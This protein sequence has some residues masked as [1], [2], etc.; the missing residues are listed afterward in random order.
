MKK[1]L[2]IIIILMLGMTN[3]TLISSAAATNSSKVIIKNTTIKCDLN[4]AS[5]LLNLKKINVKTIKYENQLY[6]PMSDGCYYFKARYKIL[7][8]EKVVH[9]LPNGKSTIKKP[10]NKKLTAVKARDISATINKYTFL[11]EGVNE[12]LDSILYENTIYVP[13]RYL[14]EMFNK[15]IEA[16]ADGSLIITDIPE[17]VI[18]S[19]DGEK[20]TQRDLDYFYIP[21]SNKLAQQYKGTQ[22]EQEKLKLKKSLFETIVE[23]KIYYKRAIQNK[24]ELTLSDFE[25]INKETITNMINNYG[26]ITSFRKLLMDNDTYFH[27]VLMYSIQGRVISKYLTK[28]LINIVATEADMKQYY[29]ANKNTF[30]EPVTLK[31][32][33]ILIM[34]KDATGNKFTEEKKVEA[35]LKAEDILTKLKNGEDFDTLMHSYSEDPGLQSYPEGYTF[36][37]DP[38]QKINP[39]WN[40][41]SNMKMVPQF[42][43]AA[44][45]MKIGEISSSIVETDFGYHIIKL[46]DIIPEKQYSFD[47]MKAYIK[48][49]L[50]NE[51]K[52]KSLADQLKQWKSK[53]KIVNLVK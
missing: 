25:I 52:N 32:K 39:E 45:A 40:V 5:I 36:S 6:I 3:F 35:K 41:S 33:H 20:I 23:N 13:A 43:E 37:K 38:G 53:I 11:Y 18:G 7:E 4:S 49:T 47:E 46:L 30:S 50:D 1:L 31:A 12:F 16:K 8:D 44:F 27:Q 10:S 26:G 21:S 42:E 28:L 22:L 34:T 15:K 19:V 2:S 51:K 14:A 24:T 48:Y 17:K 29:E 9:I